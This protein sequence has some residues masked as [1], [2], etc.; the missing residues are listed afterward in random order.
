[1]INYS[2]SGTSRYN[3]VSSLFGK[4]WTKTTLPNPMINISPPKPHGIARL[5]N[6]FGYSI[7]GLQLAWQH[8]EA[9]RLEIYILLFSIP[10]AGLIGKNIT[11][12]VLLIGSL[13]F[14][15]IIELVNS[16]IEAICDKISIAND[17]LVGRS[18]DFGAAAVFVAIIGM[19]G[20]WM[21]I[22]TKNWL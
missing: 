1:M 8:E 12:Y 4:P 14:L 7:K 16:A 15:I 19:V 17:E 18:K 11:D 5:K 6:A 2:Y 20:T 13:L 10:L 22:L 9:F 21:V 3:K